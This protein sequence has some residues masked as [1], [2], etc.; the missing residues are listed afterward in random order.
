M[1]INEGRREKLADGLAGIVLVFVT[2][3]VTG[4][5]ILLFFHILFLAVGGQHD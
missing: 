4:W 2:G 3:I 1:T 5:I